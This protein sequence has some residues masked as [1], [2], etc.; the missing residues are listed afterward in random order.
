MRRN[1]MGVKRMGG[2]EGK[3]SVYTIGS[4]GV[5][6][7]SLCLLQLKAL[8]TNLVFKVKL[9]KS[10]GLHDKTNPKVR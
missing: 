6:W 10:Q 4:N 5:F 8:D 3:G 1:R 7:D 9:E 2:G